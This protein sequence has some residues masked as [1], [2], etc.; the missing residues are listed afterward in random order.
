MKTDK[1]ET[2]LHWSELCYKL[3]V[4]IFLITLYEKAEEY[5]GIYTSKTQVIHEK[6]L[7]IK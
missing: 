5:Y 4:T 6:F 2:I 3:K 1:A 7:N